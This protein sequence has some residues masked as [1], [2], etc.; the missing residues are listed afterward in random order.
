M[1]KRCPMCDLE[2]EHQE[3]EPDVGIESGWYC[4]HCDSLSSDEDDYYEEDWR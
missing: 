2:M 1:T 3:S 4:A